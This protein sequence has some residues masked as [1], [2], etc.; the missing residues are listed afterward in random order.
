MIFFETQVWQVF[1]YTLIIAAP[2][3]VLTVGG[4]PDK[5]GTTIVQVPPGFSDQV[6]GKWRHSF[7]TI[8]SSSPSQTCG[9]SSPLPGD[10]NARMV[11][12][13]LDGERPIICGGGSPLTNECYEFS[14][15]TGDWAK[16]D[17]RQDRKRGI[18]LKK[19]F[20]F[21]ETKS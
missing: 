10:G 19:S 15:E 21:R 8:I 13:L 2:V 11:G 20:K 12:A 4:P 16:S 17:I 6:R 7:E 1:F 9:T 18:F 3:K 14:I 5:A